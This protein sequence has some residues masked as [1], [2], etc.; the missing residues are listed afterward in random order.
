MTAPSHHHA[1]QAPAVIV[2][3]LVT[4]T[5]TD[6]MDAAGWQ[7]QCRGVCGNHHSKTAGR[8]PAGTQTPARRLFAADPTSDTAS[9]DPEQLTAWCAE[10]LDGARRAANRAQRKDSADPTRAPSS[11]PAAS[12]AVPDGERSDPRSERT[13]RDRQRPG[14][15]RPRRP[16]TADRRPPRRPTARHQPRLG[17][18]PRRRRRTAQPTPR[19]PRLRRDREAARPRR[20]PVSG[21]S[22]R[23]V[24]VPGVV[25]YPRGNKWS[26]RI[27]LE[28]HQLTDKRQWEY[29]NGFPDEE[30][31]WTAA[32]RAKQQHATGQRV[33]PARRTVAD[34]FEAWLPSIKDTVKPSTYVNYRDYWQAYV[35]PVIGEGRLQKIDVP[36]LNA[37]YQHLL[38]DGRRKTDTNSLMYAYWS[39]RQKGGATA[40]TPREVAAH[41]GVSIQGARKA[42]ARYRSGRVPVATDPGLAPKTVKNIHRMLHRALSDAVAWRWIGYNPAVHASLPRAKRR[43]RLRTGAT[44]T[45]EQ[46]AAWLEVALKDRD[47]AM[48]ALAASTGMRRSELAGSTASSWTSNTP[49]SRS[50]TPV[51]SSTAT[52]RS[53]TARRPAASG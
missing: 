44:W 38:D 49:R 51:S 35:E 1:Q 47:A 15:R 39:A 2:P 48:W 45:P 43:R 29:V 7:C 33:S 20:R 17:L 36:K 11:P 31:A 37:F 53:R 50:R 12:G 41:C 30:A 22:R 23:R 24:G 26:Y 14:R 4:A 32:I 27:E 8:C 13:H 10:C 9:G 25:V 46:L 3:L 28:R 34:F 40:P 19:R 16:P 6:V 21:T 52:P 5:W 18:P 42:V